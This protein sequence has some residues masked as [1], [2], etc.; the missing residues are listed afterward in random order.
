MDGSWFPLKASRENVGISHLIF[1]DNLILF[2]KVNNKNCEAI[3]E[4][5]QTFC[6]ESG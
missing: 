3:A 5:L 4:V 2:V 1:A 6:S